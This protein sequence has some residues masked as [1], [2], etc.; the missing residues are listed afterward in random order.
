MIYA[1][2]PGPGRIRQF[3]LQRQL[4]ALRQMRT[5]LTIYLTT[6]L[7]VVIV[8]YEPS[9]PEVPHQAGKT[10]SKPEATMCL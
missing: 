3:Y 8:I 1:I 2:V 7:V 5:L 9:R 10:K 4:G 6:A